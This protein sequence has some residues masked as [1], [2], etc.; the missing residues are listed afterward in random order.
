MVGGRK[1]G[2]LNCNKIWREWCLFL[3]KKFFKS[4]FFLNLLRKKIFHQGTPIFCE[5]VQNTACND[6]LKDWHLLRRVGSA[7]NPVVCI[8][9][10]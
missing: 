5:T 1:L 3:H 9:A 2:T 10:S 8:S 6:S 7:I 4:V